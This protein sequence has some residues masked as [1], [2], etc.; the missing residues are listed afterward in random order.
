MP[1]GGW[2]DKRLSGS[3][4]PHAKKLHWNNKLLSVP[5]CSCGVTWQEPAPRRPQPFRPGTRL[6]RARWRPRR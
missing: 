3:C 5:V 2:S 4:S 6:H 1:G